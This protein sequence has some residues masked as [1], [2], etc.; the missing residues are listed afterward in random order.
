M[1]QLSVRLPNTSTVFL[2]CVVPCGGLHDPLRLPGL[3]HFTEHMVARNARTLGDDYTLEYE[4]ALKFGSW[5]DAYT[6]LTDTTYEIE[7]LSEHYEQARAWLTQVVTSLPF[8]A[9]DWRREQRVLWLQI[10]DREYGY[11]TDRLLR[12]LV[13]GARSRHAR[14]IGGTVASLER[15]T[16]DDIRRFWRRHYKPEQM[17]LLE[18]GALPHGIEPDALATLNKSDHFLTRDLRSAVP[19]AGPLVHFTPRRR[20][21]IDIDFVFLLP[22]EFAR[23]PELLFCALMLYRILEAKL[24]QRLRHWEG[25]ISEIEMGIEFHPL[26]LYVG[27]EA[28]GKQ[29]LS[30]VKRA[31]EAVW[32]CRSPTMD[33]LLMSARLALSYLRSLLGSPHRFGRHLLTPTGIYW[34]EEM[35]FVQR[36]IASPEAYLDTLRAAAER[37][38]HAERLVLFLRGVFSS[39]A[40]E[41]IREKLANL[42]GSSHGDAC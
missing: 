2:A 7:T 1:Q 27:A 31:L 8:S 24:L 36:V 33:D 34:A 16:P 9:A 20:D 29:P 35:D 28:N 18:V 4:A 21:T 37:A 19:F 30:V 14:L 3:A 23:E 10:R 41:Q 5:F 25:D 17:W 42:V 13:Y 40:R 15:T 32:A 39:K 11:Y 22:E 12:R 26:R 38:I 6:T